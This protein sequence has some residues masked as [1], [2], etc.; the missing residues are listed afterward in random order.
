MCDEKQTHAHRN[1][2]ASE[3]FLISS[4]TQTAGHMLSLAGL[5]E[6]ERPDNSRVL[7]I[8]KCKPAK[9]D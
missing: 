8:T 7:W 1:R 6:G 3:Y 4:H 9:H 5:D 2:P